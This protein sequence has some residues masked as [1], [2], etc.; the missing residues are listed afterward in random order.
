MPKHTSQWS[1]IKPRASYHTP[2]PPSASESSNTN[3]VNDLLSHLRH[4]Q[5]HHDAPSSLLPPSTAPSIPPGLQSILGTPAPPPP[6]PRTRVSVPRNRRIPGPPPPASWL[7]PDPD[8]GSIVTPTFSTCGETEQGAGLLPL[9]GLP[10]LPAEDSLQHYTLLRLARDWDFH[11]VYDQHY[12]CE[13]PSRWKSVLLHYI[14]RY[15]SRGITAA[16]LEVLLAE[17]E[18]EEEGAEAVSYLDLSRADI[19][20][21][22]P[23]FRQTSGEPQQEGVAESWD[24]APTA[25]TWEEVT[26]ISL[27]YPRRVELSP[28]LQLLEAMPGITHLS[29]L[30]WSALGLKLKMV[31]KLALCIRWV[32]VDKESM[33]TLATMEAWTGAWRGVEKVRVCGM[34]RERAEEVQRLVRRMRKGVGRWFEVEVV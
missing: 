15:S 29:L 1:H 19:K 16:G 21:L 11:C 31:T 10:Q 28:L 13:L 4:S 26:H 2:R 23:F 9:P 12:L 30:G 8:T 3:S 34:E 25:R 33:E 32:E 7:L 14:A 18:N 24:L 5:P 6:R 17:D 27:S 22:A 20:D